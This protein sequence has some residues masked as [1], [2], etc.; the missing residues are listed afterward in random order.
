MADV[1]ITIRKT[2]DGSDTTIMVNGRIDDSDLDPITNQ[3]T[4][5][6]YTSANTPVPAAPAPTASV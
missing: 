6:L 2:V 4:Q 5:L 1:S 3:L